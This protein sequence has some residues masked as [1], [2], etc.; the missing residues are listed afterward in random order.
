MHNNQ[1]IGFSIRIVSNLIKRKVESYLSSKHCIAITSLQGK[2][3]GYLYSHSEK[4]IFQKDLEE[5]FSVRR[6]TVTEV[7]K[8]MEKNGL[9][10]R[11]SVEKDAR[12]KKIVITE[13]A[14]NLHLKIL[15]DIKE[16]EKIIKKGISEEEL[17][18]FMSILNKIKN[19]VE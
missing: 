18:L 7:L 11:H 5:I 4:D 10:E 14:I 3:A 16:I 13:K 12:L 8:T 2:I 15:E 17:I 19:N 6:S 9:I 1:D